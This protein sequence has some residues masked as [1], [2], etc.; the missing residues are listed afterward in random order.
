VKAAGEAYKKELQ[1]RKRLENEAYLAAVKRVAAERGVSAKD[2][3][4]ALSGTYGHYQDLK[5]VQPTGVRQTV[6]GS[7]M[8]ARTGTET[9]AQNR[10]EKLGE[11]LRH[12][13]DTELQS[14]QALG[15]QAQR[16][17]NEIAQV[18][19]QLT[20]VLNGRQPG[21]TGG[22]GGITGGGRS[23]G[24]SSKGF[25]I[26]SIAFDANKAMLSGVK[27]EDAMPSVAEMVKPENIFGQ[28]DEWE[29]YKDTITGSI[30]SIGESMSNLTQWTSDFDPYRENMEKMT[31]AAKQQRM[32]FG[33]AGQAAENFG[34]ALAGMDDPAARAAGTVISAIANIALGFGMAVAQASSMGPWAWLAYVAAGTAALATT[35]STVHQ[36]T[37]FAEGGIVGGNQY[38]GDNIYAGNAMVNSGELVLNKAQQG[39]LAS[40][41]QGNGLQ[42]MN[43]SGRI[44]GTDIILS[45]DR[46]LQL[47]G[48]Q[49]LT[50]G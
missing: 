29:K 12:L 35:I 44:K 8:F 49:L 37:G 1:D 31:K 16:T 18:D 11:A 2:L 14:L 28:T 30:G 13:N 46:S 21:V 47:E 38:S 45:I 9:F 27:A 25:D 26:S 19:K 6:V 50:W 7:G 24:G 22:S 10:Q 17:G 3:T 36:L 43:I 34:A 32:A 42:N 48:K 33:M 4:D 5:N 39:N 20:R 23:G 15:A 40:Q 41:L